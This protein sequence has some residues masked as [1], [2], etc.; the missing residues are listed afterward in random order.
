MDILPLIKENYPFEVKSQLDEGIIDTSQGRKRY[1]IWHD[2]ALLNWHQEWREKCS[3]NPY[4]L[5]DRMLQTKDKK[6]AIKLEEGWLTVHDDI[7]DPYP[8]K[9][10]EQKWAH[11]IARMIE[12]GTA[13][14]DERIS[15]AKRE[16]PSTS[17]WKV[18]V[19]K[20]MLLDEKKRNI[21]QSCIQEA[22]RRKHKALE[23]RKKSKEKRLP[24]M[25]KVSSTTQAKK[26]YEL[27]VWQGTAEAPEYGF[28]SLTHFLQQW[29]GEN[30]EESLVKLL[31][32]IEEQIP[33]RQMYGNELLAE[34]W[35]P[36]EL[37]HAMEL[38]QQSEEKEEIEIHFS[39]FEREWNDRRKLVLT[40]L[41]WV[42]EDRKK[43][44]T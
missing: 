29:V 22:M 11:F 38:L 40:L 33:F 9:D 12:F 6:K 43:V 14:K 23:L 17:E 18:W 26:I 42:K 32:E 15:T 1:R 8:T 10:F 20:T 2:E 24:I 44:A 19:S 36:W 3:R 34:A 37:V 16:F 28:V 25:D 7:I 4:Q 39:T 21:L 41:N 13:T 27:F 30:G 31:N 35:L 5:T